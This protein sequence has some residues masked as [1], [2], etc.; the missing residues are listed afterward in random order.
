MIF[1]PPPS[2]HFRRVVLVGVVC[3]LA[4][5]SGVVFVAADNDVNL[6]TAVSSSSPTAAIGAPG[7]TRIAEQFGAL[8]LSFEINQ[9]QVD[10]SVKFLSHGP[11]YDLF[12][13]ATEAVL[14][15]QKPR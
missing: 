7:K 12:L 14:R 1:L 9:G 13:T 10:Q 11:G 8:P 2:L 5:L 3:L 4:T 15:L 6:A